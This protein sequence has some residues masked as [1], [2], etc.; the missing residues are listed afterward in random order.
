MSDWVGLLLKAVYYYGRII[1]LGNFDI[2]WRKGRVFTALRSSLYVLAINVIILVVM[3]LQIFKRTDPNVVFEKANALHQTLI[4]VVVGIKLASGLCTVINRWRQRAKFMRL[5]RKMLQLSLEKPQVKRMSRWG[6]L[7][8][9][10]I[11]I[12]TDLLQ[13]AISWDSAD[14][15]DSNQFLGM[16]FQFW[17]SAI[18]NLAISQHYLVTLFVRA[19]YNLLNTELRTVINESKMLSYFTVR[20]GVFMTRCC[21]LADKVDSIA[22]LQYRLQ[23][24]INQMNAVVGVQGLLVY[25]GYY[26]FSISTTY[27][28]YSI[29]KN[30]IENLQLTIKSVILAFCW[31]FFYY[32]DATINLFIMINLLDDHK[33]MLRLLEE[34]TLFAPGLDARLEESFESIQLQL[35]R[36]PFKIEVL[37]MFS[38]TRSSTTAMFG[39]LITHS[40]FLIQCDMEYF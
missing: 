7:I 8:K 19:Y 9:V 22:K 27:V 20:R 24:I 37:K 18:I 34:R 2:D 4:I 12:V 25:A 21:F 31:C 13:M 10:V 1:G 5:A 6:I 23:T 36:N 40:I 33:E 11:A 39:S 29:H 32:L 16:I 38:I 15:V 14:R 30:G 26:I 28:T 17:L 35:V 3:F